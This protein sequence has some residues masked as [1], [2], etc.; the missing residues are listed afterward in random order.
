MGVAY[1]VPLIPT[2]ETMNTFET[3]RDGTS[4]L[5]TPLNITLIKAILPLEGLMFRIIL[6]MHRPSFLFPPALETLLQQQGR[7]RPP[8][9]LDTSITMCVK[10]YISS[11]HVDFL[12]ESALI[13]TPASSNSSCGY[14][15]SSCSLSAWLPSAGI[16]HLT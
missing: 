5:P 15:G 2:L 1:P 9:I 6:P 12:T 14:S 3:R 11:L 8:S 10:N 4:L 7:P 16:E 13:W